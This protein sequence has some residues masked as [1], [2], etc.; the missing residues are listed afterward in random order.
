[1][2]DVAREGTTCPA[3]LW[4]EGISHAYGGKPVVRGVDLA[5]APGEL[6]CLLGPSGCGK[7]TTLRIA[8]GL[9]RPAEGRVMLNCQLVS[10]PGTHVPPE[11][12]HVGFLFQDYAL[13]PHLDVA[14]NVAFGIE[15]LPKPAR[16][17]RVMEML[18]QVGME[19]YAEAWPHQL[20][21]GQQQRVALARALAP[22]PRLMLLDEPFSGLDK[23]LRDQV[24]D[25]TLH[26]LKSSGVST[27]MV[28]HD[29]EEA[30]F[31]A[32]RIAIMRDGRIV[33]QGRPDELYCA[34]ADPFVAS[35][36]GEVNVLEG[37]V[38]GGAVATPFGP[39]PVPG[40]AEGARCQVVVRPEALHLS[41]APDG[42]AEVIAARML[43]RSSLVH[44]RVQGLHLHARMPGRFLPAEGQRLA[45]A[46]DP[47][48]VHVFPAADTN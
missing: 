21:G 43:G 47:S 19:A 30:M 15:G 26:V 28:T 22:K 32:D 7:T 9:E 2:K 14:A 3:G 25:E 46:L 39:R 5:V 1:M 42:V 37:R 34:P 44:L 41:P 38:E 48:Q 33:Q 17:Q 4:L 16:R 31:M 35:F 13:F 40:L 11:G 36:F 6:V 45:V 20:S 12:R 10:G 23:R 24:R 18:A 27:L 29:P 8:A